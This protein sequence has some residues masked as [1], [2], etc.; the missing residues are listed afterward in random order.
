MLFFSLWLPF[1]YEDDDQQFGEFKDM[2]TT[3]PKFVGFLMLDFMIVNSTVIEMH[4]DMFRIS[5]GF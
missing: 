4:D 1:K 3:C 2:L 5:Y